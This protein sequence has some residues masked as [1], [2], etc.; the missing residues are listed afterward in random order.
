MTAQIAERL[1]YQGE[2]MALCA[3]P[4]DDYFDLGG[5][6]PPFVASSTAL[7]RGYVGSWEIVDGR[8]YLV[9]LEGL[10][11]DGSEATLA[12][13]FPGFPDRVFAHWYSGILRVPQGRQLLYV[14]AGYNSRYERDLLL[15]V[16]RGVVT[17][18]R[19]R[20]NGTAISE[21]AQE[22]YAIGAMTTLPG[23]SA[24]GARK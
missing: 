7:W 20:H 22:G 23:G 5:E 6:K 21:D 11:E 15:E 2:E 10:L 13:V 19:T 17:A 1:R 9:G 4:L 8:L 24:G 12:S 16:E 14:H 3:N 18:T